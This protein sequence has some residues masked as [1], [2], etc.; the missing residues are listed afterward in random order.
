MNAD[1]GQ[2][3]HGFCLNCNKIK[4]VGFIRVGNGEHAP[5]NIVCHE[6]KFIIASLYKRPTMTEPAFMRAES[7]LPPRE[8]S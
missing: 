3:T 1:N 2:Y 7:T 5:T 4:P 6:C 8:V